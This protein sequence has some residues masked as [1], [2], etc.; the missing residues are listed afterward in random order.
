MNSL[1]VVFWTFLGLAVGS[2]V[3]VLIYRLPEGKSLFFPA[4]H[5]PAC[6]RRIAFYDNVPLVSY[7]ILRG[8]C[9]SCRARIPARYP[10]VEAAVGLLALGLR[11]RWG[12]APAWLGASVAACGILVAVTFIDWRT[13]IIP[14]ELSL[15][16]LALGVVCCPFNP[17]FS[18]KLAAKLLASAG[19]GAAGFAMCWAVAAVGE[20]VFKKEAMG[21]G[22]IKLLAG[23]GAWSG[24]L[25]AFDCLL[26][27]SLLGALYGAALLARGRVK[28]QDP[29]PFGPFLSA[30]AVLNLFYVLPFGFPFSLWT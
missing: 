27:G 3:N 30:A 12:P 19:G 20:W 13:F 22:D 5:C 16:L 1:D 8:R 23:V 26:V 14:D 25:G 4:S 10:A 2:F 29:I 7:A 6:G 18:G 28:R 24:V 9:R 21:G 11:L 17:I 15:G